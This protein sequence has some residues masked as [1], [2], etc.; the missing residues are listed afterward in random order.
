MN[1]NLTVSAFHLFCLLCLCVVAC[2]FRFLLVVG[3]LSSMVFRLLLFSFVGAIALSLAMSVPLQAAPD[4]FGS[5]SV[6]PFIAF[7]VDLF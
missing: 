2:P 4:Q 3:M 7:I 6:A 5:P 1:E